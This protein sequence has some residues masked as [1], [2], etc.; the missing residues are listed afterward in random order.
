MTAK[1]LREFIRNLP[2]RSVVVVFPYET[3]NLT[4]SQ[5][6]ESVSNSHADSFIFDQSGWYVLTKLESSNG[7]IRMTFGWRY[8][9]YANQF[10]LSSKFRAMIG[11]ELCSRLDDEIGIAYATFQ[12]GLTLDSLT[13][14]MPGLHL[15]ADKVHRKLP[16]NHLAS[17]LISDP[18]AL[19]SS[20]IEVWR[21]DP[22]FIK[23]RVSGGG[24]GLMGALEGMAI[25]HSIN[26]FIDSKNNKVKKAHFE[27]IELPLNFGFLH[28]RAT[29]RFIE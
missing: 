7:W 22:G 29:Q 3:I 4:M 18:I 20:A 24:F 17:R 13:R 1:D 5:V 27:T 14:A 28:L 15:C 8:W 19:L 9:I 26:S 2:D 25:A 10:G 23:T 21:K 12:S 6:K 11:P 16:Q